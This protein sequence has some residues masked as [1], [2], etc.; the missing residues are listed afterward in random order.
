MQEQF[1]INGFSDELI[2][3]NF[4][5]QALAFEVL[6]FGEFTLKSG[7]VS[8]YFFNMG[9]ID[10]GFKSTVVAFLYAAGI[11]KRVEDQEEA[12][13]FNCIFGPAY[14][15]IPLAVSTAMQINGLYQRDVSWAFN[16]KEIK[17]HG[18]G[19][20]IVGAP[21]ENKILIVDDVITA[22]TAIRQSI[23]LIRSEGAEVA[24][25]FVA[26]DRQEVGIDS[27]LSAVQQIQQ[28]FGVKVYSLIT[29]ADIIQH[30]PEEHQE[31]LMAYRNKYGV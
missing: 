9:K 12:L 24:G 8:P 3:Q 7:R 28:E 23:D 22:G 4:V 19:G 29:L 13:D 20:S 16:R 30:C 21:L 15:G 10:T 31:A 18:E 6:Q 27:P 11:L 25:V 26:L 14:K 1:D 2:K 17:D 5:E